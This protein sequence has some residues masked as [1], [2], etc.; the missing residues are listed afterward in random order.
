MTKLYEFIFV[1]LIIIGMTSG[2]AILGKKLFG[3]NYTENRHIHVFPMRA[4]INLPKDVNGYPNGYV[5]IEDAT[6]STW[7]GKT[8]EEAYENALRLFNS[9][10]KLGWSNGVHSK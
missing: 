7:Y 2:A 6:Y 9:N 10:K 4:F 8:Q 1:L 3:D 5:A